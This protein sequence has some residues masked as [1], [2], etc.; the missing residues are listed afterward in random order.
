MNELVK[1]RDL[2]EKYDISSRTLRYYEDSGLIESKRS[3]D[4]AYRLYDENAVKRLEQI[5][6]LRKLNIS[7]KDIK[8]IFDA[9][10][11]GV[12]LEVLNQKI[13]SI[14]NETALLHELKA[15]ISDF[16]NQIKILDFQNEADIKTLYEKTKELEKNITVTESA[17][18]EPELGKLNSVTDK[19][20][21][22]PEVRILDFPPCKM[23]SSG[24]F[25]SFST[26]FEKGGFDEWF[27]Q[28]D[29]S[30]KG[31]RFT[32]LDF[33]FFEPDGRGMW[34]Y[35]VESSV[36]ENETG[37]FKI[38]D[39]EGGLYAAA[40]SVDGDDDINGRVYAG[41]KK[42]IESSNFELDERPMHRTLCNMI[43]TDN[44]RKGLGYDQL[45]IFV[46]IK[47]KTKD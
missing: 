40:I 2:S 28:Y 19:L 44:I 21:K 39:F 9:D 45:E 18:K 38:I 43:V 37:G 33:L 14:D 15:I 16:I 35:A 30:Y 3:E 24:Y 23:V 29:K 34:L 20:K 22:A 41:I 13:I 1:I 4:Y 42:W 12:I 10:S 25:T 11:T 26:V 47:L 27:S 6:T 36:T 7:I 8:R 46:P 32:P 5:L 17:K 31:V